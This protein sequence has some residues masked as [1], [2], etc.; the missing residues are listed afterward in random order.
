MYSENF[1]KEGKKSVWVSLAFAELGLVVWLLP[2]AFINVRLQNE[3]EA[4]LMILLGCGILSG[5]FGVSWAFRID[6]RLGDSQR[7]VI[8]WRGVS[9]IACCVIV[10]LLKTILRRFGI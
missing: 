9:S 3:L 4:P 8:I 2:R 1:A 7:G 10:I 5:I 6:K